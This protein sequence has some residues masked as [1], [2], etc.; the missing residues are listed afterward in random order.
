M[1]IQE[2]T[3]DLEPEEVIARAR[4]FFTERY[5][6]Y[7]GFIEDEGPTHIR[8]R[9]EA[10]TLMIGVG[11]RDGRNVVRGS[12]ARLQHELSQFLSGLAL[13]E[14]VRRNRIGRA[15]ALPAA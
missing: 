7:A 6:P 14:E 3:T 10:G 1:L 2:V 5:S 9:V 4:V 13:P 12:T 11:R 15:S 8:F